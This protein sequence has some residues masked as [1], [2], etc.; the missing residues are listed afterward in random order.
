[1][2]S[3]GET[4]VFNGYWVFDKKWGKQFKFHSYESVI[5]ATLEGIKRFLASKYID[6]IGEKF[7]ERIV[8]T[9]G[10]DTIKVLDETPEK[11]RKVKGLSPGRIEVIKEGWAS[12][13]HI[14]DI[15][16]FLQSH[17]IS[18]TY[19]SKIYDKYQF[20]WKY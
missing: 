12:H 13:R 16:I 1:M 8:N 10:S 17:D 6:G 2:L 20:F 9:F 18:P 15:M 7:A 3:E 19:A 5:P 4:I 14:R 11:L